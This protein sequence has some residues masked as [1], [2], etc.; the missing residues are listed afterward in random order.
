MTTTPLRDELGATLY[1]QLVE[2]WRRRLAYS[3]LLSVQPYRE[4]PD[5]YVEAED[6]R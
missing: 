2:A 4:L 6:R 1:A 5:S 3:L